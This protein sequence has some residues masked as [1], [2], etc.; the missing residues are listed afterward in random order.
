MEALERE[1]GCLATEGLQWEDVERRAKEYAREKTAARR[2]RAGEAYRAVVPTWDWVQ[3]RET[4][5]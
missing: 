1:G 5:W 2:F 3:G 4:V